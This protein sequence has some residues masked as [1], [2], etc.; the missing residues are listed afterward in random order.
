MLL[1]APVDH[2]AL[3]LTETLSDKRLVIVH[4]AFSIR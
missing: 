2:R 4:A 3:P 1:I